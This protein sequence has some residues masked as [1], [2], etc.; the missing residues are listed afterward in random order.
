VEVKKSNNSDLLKGFEKQLPEY[1]KSEATDESVYLVVRVAMGDS[2]IK[3]L[4]AFRAKRL[5]ESKKVPDIFVADAR[6]KASASKQPRRRD[7][8]PLKNKR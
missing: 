2:A 8:W 1:E 4:L 6:K 3:R 7:H 5:Q